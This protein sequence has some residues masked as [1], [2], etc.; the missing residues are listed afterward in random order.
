MASG[1]ARPRPS[2]ESLRVVQE[3]AALTLALAQRLQDGYAGHAA[4]VGLT[5]AQAKVLVAL[6]PDQSVSQRELA[7]LLRADPSNLTGLIDKL[8]ARGDVRRQPDARDRRV[9]LLVLTADGARTRERFWAGL[10]SDPGPLAHLTE[11]QVR[12]LRDRL[13]EA[14]AAE[15]PR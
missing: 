15:P 4:D 12:A 6:Q 1:P 14:L 3:A 11:A 7:D 8:E 9:K 5:A 2:T 10:T 13:G